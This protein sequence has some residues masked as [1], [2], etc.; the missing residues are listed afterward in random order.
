[1]NWRLFRKIALIFA[2]LLVLLVGALLIWLS[3]LDPRAI[4]NLIAQQSEARIGR[5]LN[6]DGEIGFTWSLQPTLRITNI[7]LAN[8]SWGS[9][10]DMLRV[11]GAELQLA[12]LP[13]LRREIEVQRVLLEAPEILLEAN[14]RGDKNWVFKP[15]AQTPG[16]TDASAPQGGEAPRI[17]VASLEIRQAVLDYR[18]A[19][20]AKAQRV[21]LDKLSLRSEGARSQLDASLQAMGLA[22]AIKGELPDP[23]QLAAAR[24]PQPLNLQITLG[25]DTRIQLTGTFDPQ[26]KGA[27]DLLLATLELDAPNLQKLASQMKA[28]APRLPALKLSANTRLSSE[29]LQLDAL[30]IKLGNTQLAGSAGLAFANSAIQANLK[31]PQIDLREIGEPARAAASSSTATERPANARVF[32]DEPLP[33][34]ALAKLEARFELAVEQLIL[35]D[36]R[37]LQGLSLGARASGGKL[38]LAPA[39]IMIDGKPLRLTLDTDAGNGKTLA[40]NAAL[41]GQAIPLPALMALAGKDAKDTQ[42]GPTDIT[43]KLAGRGASVRSLA[44]GLDGDVSLIV[45]AGRWDSRLLD[46]GGNLAQFFSALNPDS[47]RGV[48]ALKCAVVRFPIRQGMAS[49]NN[50]IALETSQLLLSA[51]GSINLRDET[52]DIAARPSLPS[53]VGGDLTK[54]VQAVRLGGSFATPKVSTDARAVAGTVIELGIAAASKDKAALSRLLKP[55]T[56]T[57]LPCD[58]ALGKASAA[59]AT[60]PAA[61]QN[62]PRQQAAPKLDEAVDTL[63]RLFK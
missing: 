13:L 9:Q 57:A 26:A 52:L 28:S 42:G 23:L 58:I 20:P 63:R 29:R 4:T 32:S 38:R 7:R 12:L 15:A 34:A 40:F 39:Q 10:P 45:G 1:M 41:T 30:Q 43:V 62:N 56:P 16:S 37:K 60:E 6:I 22:V 2:S 46:F 25:G 55:G 17:A 14:A 21:N 35:K 44:A 48:S 50:G 51:G 47:V 11:A 18:P 19:A 5:A 59:P 53:G 31:G 36:G 33:L 8:A 27:A 61:T 24:E 49:I 3:Q 54:L